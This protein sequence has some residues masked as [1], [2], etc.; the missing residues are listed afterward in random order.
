MLTMLSVLLS[1]KLAQG[2]FLG[3]L[4]LK[5]L[6]LKVPLK[7]TLKLLSVQFPQGNSSVVLFV[8]VLLLVLLSV[9]LLLFHCTT[10]LLPCKNREAATLPT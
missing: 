5:L 8:L 9:R 2:S 6:P 3:L 10:P 7:L 4:L 1:V